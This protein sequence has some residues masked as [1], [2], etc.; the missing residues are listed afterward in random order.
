MADNDSPKIRLQDVFESDEIA[1]EELMGR[2]N[3]GEAPWIDGRFSN[4]VVNEIED[5]A[6]RYELTRKEAIVA[7]VRAGLDTPTAIE[8]QVCT[9]EWG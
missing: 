5:V 8:E 9:G 2:F 3:T 7:I 1:E 6:E 4:E